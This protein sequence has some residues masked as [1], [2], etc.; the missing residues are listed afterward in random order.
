MALHILVIDNDSALASALRHVFEPK[1]WTMEVVDDPNLALQM[2]AAERPDLILLGVELPK[3]NGFVVCNR[4]KR[5]PNLLSIPVFIMSAEVSR[6]N[7]DQHRKTRTRADQYLDKAEVP[8]TVVEQ[9]EHWLATGAGNTATSQPTGDTETLSDDELV[10]ED[11]LEAVPTIPPTAPRHADSEV[12]DLANRAFDQLMSEPP[13]IPRAAAAPPELVLTP[14]Q[15]SV[16]PKPSTPSRPLRASESEPPSALV[17]ELAELRTILAQERGELEEL[18]AKLAQPAPRASG[19]GASAREILDLREQL[20]KKDKELLEARDRQTQKDKELLSLRESVLAIEREKADLMDRADEATAK[21]QDVQRHADAA[22]ADKEAA[23]KR[24]EDAK[25]RTEKVTAQLEEKTRELSE[26]RERAAAREKELTD[27]AKQQLE[28]ERERARSEL[29]A[30]V[31]SEKAHAREQLEAAEQRHK[32]ALEQARTEAAQN[33]QAAVDDERSRAEER[34]RESEQHHQQNLEATLEAARRTAE[35]ERAEAVTA[36]VAHAEEQARTELERRLAETER[37]GIAHEESALAEAARAAA[38]Q[39]REGLAEQERRLV[40]E[41]ARE[42]KGL[43]DTAAE[44]RGALEQ[45]LDQLRQNNQQLDARLAAASAAWQQ[46][47]QHLE[48]IKDCLATT[49]LEVEAI[50]HQTRTTASE[51]PSGATSAP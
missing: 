21:L 18:R 23:G 32:Q 36:A 6:T 51:S 42:R 38:D 50:E 47:R 14:E 11:D 4:L 2:A 27:Q 8:S 33:K 25:R 40:D 12:E 39:L 15:V 5:D 7:I 31:Q 3:T 35:T 26:E 1:G 9:I 46:D 29:E 28:L 37:A 30:A 22:R 10:L 49:L 17:T 20:N 24:A 16:A 44:E 13:A 41:F 34:L 43:V 45:K 19:A 48:R